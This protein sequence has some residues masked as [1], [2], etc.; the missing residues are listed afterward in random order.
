ME[1][2][3][4]NSVGSGGEGAAISPL[5]ELLTLPRTQ[6]SPGDLVKMWILSPQVWG[7][8]ESE[9]LTGPQVTLLLLVHGPSLEEPR[10]LRNTSGGGVDGRERQK[11]DRSSQPVSLW[12]SVS[13]SGFSGF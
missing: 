12:L 10:S 13:R 2:W 1:G 4:S 9:F 7:G 5:I 6:Q 11:R 8:A 3:V